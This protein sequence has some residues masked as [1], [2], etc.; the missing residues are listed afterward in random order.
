[1]GGGGVEHQYLYTTL[2]QTALGFMKSMG[3][4][5]QWAYVVL[6]IEYL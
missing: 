3:T 2:Q 4:V 1:M 6:L 5:I